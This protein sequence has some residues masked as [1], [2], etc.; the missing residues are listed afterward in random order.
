MVAGS[1][2]DLC[3]ALAQVNRIGEAVARQVHLVDFKGPPFEERPKRV[4]TTFLLARRGGIRRLIHGRG[5]GKIQATRPAAR[6]A[7][8][9]VEASARSTCAR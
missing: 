4:A 7:V 2:A 1:C 5:I 6:A 8:R 9:G 3:D